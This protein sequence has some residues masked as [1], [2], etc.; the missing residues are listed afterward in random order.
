LLLL[1]C[2]ELIHINQSGQQSGNKTSQGA[3]LNSM[4]PPN[5]HSTAS[6]AD[7]RQT[8][9]RPRESDG[10]GNALRNIFAGAPQL[11]HELSNLIG[12]LNRHD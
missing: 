10:V 8:V 11:P 7:L 5:P 3:F 9:K 6:N 2:H 4:S 1:Q 12:R